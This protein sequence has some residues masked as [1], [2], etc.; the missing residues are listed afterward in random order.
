MIFIMRFH[1]KLQT[2]LSLCM[3]AV[4]AHSLPS[5]DRRQ[6]PDPKYV[7]AH[8]IVGNLDGYTVDQWTNDIVLAQEN[9]IDGFALNIGPDPYTGD[10]LNNA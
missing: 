4:S 7:V 10:Q 2:L 9:G 8:V 1:S 3:L 6:A 5:H